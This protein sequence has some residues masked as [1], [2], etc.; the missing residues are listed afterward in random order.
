M[1]PSNPITV[2]VNGFITENVIQ[3]VIKKHLPGYGILFT[4]GH[5]THSDQ[6]RLLEAGYKPAKDSSHLYNLA[7]D[8]VLIN[9]NTG[10]QI[11]GETMEALYFDKFKPFFPGYSYFDPARPGVKGAHIHANLPRELTDKTK[12]I[13]YLGAGFVLF[14]LF[15]QGLKKLQ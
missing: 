3:S 13:G 8:F 2:A 7:R 6:E 4:S 15:K 12:I 5:R 9:A 14:I 1:I 10:E 11:N